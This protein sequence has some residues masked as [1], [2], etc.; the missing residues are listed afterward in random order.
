MIFFQFKL[1]WANLR[2]GEGDTYACYA[3]GYSSSD[4]NL[5]Y[6]GSTINCQNKCSNRPRFGRRMMVC[7]TKQKEQGKRRDNKY[8]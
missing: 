5:T 3:T 7:M 8:F 2:G 6:A 1:L 4:N